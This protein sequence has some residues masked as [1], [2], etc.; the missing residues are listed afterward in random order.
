M[1]LPPA[2][3]SELSL[4]G[5]SEAERGAYR[6]LVRGD[7]VSVDELSRHLGLDTSEVESLV[8]NLQRHELITSGPDG[9]LTPSPPDVS[10]QTLLLREQERVNSALQQLEQMRLWTS[11]LAMEYRAARVADQ[12]ADLLE[13]VVGADEAHRRDSQIQNLARFEVLVLDKP[14]YP[15]SSGINPLERERLAAGVR[16]RGIYEQEA[17]TA[18]RLADI[19]ASIAAGEEARIAPT[20]PLKLEIADRR[21]AL[22]P[23]RMESGKPEAMRIVML[24]ESPLVEALVALFELLWDRATPI[25]TGAPAAA[26]PAAAAPARSAHGDVITLLAAGLK[27][28]VIAARLGLSLRTVRRHIAEILRDLNVTSRFQAGLEAR[29]RG[30]V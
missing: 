17:L 22:I 29:R 2:T 4:L 3:E 30:L 28:E 8:E 10:L 13:V 11:T 19:E 24:Y 15:V 18:D 1:K 6:F 26:A 14:P 27:D 7:A 12:H 23:L 16:Y 25:S 20:L 5:L 21:M 9:I